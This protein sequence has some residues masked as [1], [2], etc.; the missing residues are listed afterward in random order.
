[1]RGGGCTL[2]QS[3]AF[4]VDGAHLAGRRGRQEAPG[5][6]VVGKTNPADHAQNLIAGGKRIV[7][8][9][10]PLALM[11]HLDPDLVALRFDLSCLNDVAEVDRLAPRDDCGGAARRGV[12]G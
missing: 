10:L 5:V 3:G 4:R 11:T 9:S 7:Q 12:A 1:M 8:L 6:A 2:P